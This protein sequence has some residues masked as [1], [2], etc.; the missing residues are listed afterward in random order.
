[1]VYNMILTHINV[2][3]LSIDIIHS[4]IIFLYKNK[5]DHNIINNSK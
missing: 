1:M 3:S 5:N 4:Y 2:T